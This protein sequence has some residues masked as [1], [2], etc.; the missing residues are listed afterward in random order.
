[1]GTDPS[2]T[3]RRTQFATKK[4]AVQEL[5]GGESVARDMQ[6]CVYDM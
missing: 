2:S 1:M 3:R 4:E 5:A 6:S